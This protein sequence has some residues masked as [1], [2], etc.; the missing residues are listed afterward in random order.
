MQSSKLGCY[1]NQIFRLLDLDHPMIQ[2]SPILLT[3]PFPYLARS[4]LTPEVSNS[5]PPDLS[6]PWLH[7]HQCDHR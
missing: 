6:G 1:L 4:L 3:P 7:Q 5:M 2:T